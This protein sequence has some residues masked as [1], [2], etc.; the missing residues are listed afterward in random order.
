[1]HGFHSFLM[2]HKAL[3][4]S[5]APRAGERGGLVD[6]HGPA[7][8]FSRKWRAF[9]SVQSKEDFLLLSRGQT[10]L[11]DQLEILAFTRGGPRAQRRGRTQCEATTHFS[12][13]GESVNYVQ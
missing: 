7:P 10:S 4:G 12:H 11:G 13:C 5:L 9:F 6:A 2:T 8:G 3:R 1:L